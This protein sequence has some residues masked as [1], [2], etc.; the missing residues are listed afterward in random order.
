MNSGKIAFTYEFEIYKAT[1]TELIEAGRYNYLN[2]SVIEKY[3]PVREDYYS[4]GLRSFKFIKFGYVEIDFIF[5]I[6]TE[7]GLQLPR[8]ED[9]LYLGAQFD[10]FSKDKLVPE[11][12]FLHGPKKVRKKKRVISLS[13]LRKLGLDLYLDPFSRWWNGVAWFAFV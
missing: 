13:Y 10:E 1:T 4:L 9:A 5:N 3:F 7:L 6:V 8:Y 12:T 2:R 11:I